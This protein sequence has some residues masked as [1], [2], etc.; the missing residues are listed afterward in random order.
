[1]ACA[2]AI[3]SIVMTAVG[4]YVANGGLNEVFGG[5]PVSGTGQ[6]L[7]G[8][9]QVQV[10]MPDGTS[11]IM[12]NVQ[13]VQKGFLDA[14]S[15]GFFDSLK[16]TLSDMYNSVIEFTAPMKE[17][18]QQMANAP[19]A[20]GNEVFLQT[21]GT[22][23]PKTAGL[24]QTLTE[25]SFKAALTM[26]QTWAVQSLGGAG[27][28]AGGIIQGDP[29]VLGGIY[30][31]AQSLVNGANS[32]VNAAEKSGEWLKT[33]FTTMDKTITAG[34]TGVSNW[35]EGLGDDIKNLGQTVSWENVNN[36]GS[37]GQLLANMENNGTLGPL[38]SKLSNITIS[39]K[40]A[41]ELGYNIAKAGVDIVTGKKASVGVAD[42]TN[43]VVTLGSLGVDLNSLART[44]AY[45]PAP[46]QKQVF[47]VLGTLTPTE[48]AQ[49]K[50][51]LNNKQQ[52]V[53]T[54]QDLLNPQKLFGK[55]YTTLT[56]PVRTA[57]VGFRAIYE[58]ESGSV[59]PQLNHLGGK[60][61]GIIPD[62]LAVANDALARSLLQIKG[63]QNTSTEV[64]AATISS[65]EV[66]EDLPLIQNQKQYITDPVA[67]YWKNTFNTDTSDIP[68]GTGPY[69]KLVVCDVIGLAAGYNSGPN[70]VEN[71]ELLAKLEAQ[72]AFDEFTTTQG[73]YE[74]IQE[75]CAGTFGPTED[76]MTPG[77]WYV[78]I[79]SGW[80]AAGT[81]GPFATEE[82]AFED[83]WLTGII[84]ATVL[85]NVDI[86]ANNTEAQ[87]VYTN[88]IRW[89]EQQGREYLN[90]QRA[91][92][93]VTAIPPTV[94]NAMA[95]ADSVKSAAEDTQ[96]GGGAMFFERVIDASTLGGQATVAMMRE[97]RNF[98]TLAA[99]GLQ[100][101]AA[102]PTDGIEEPG[103]LAPS[104]YTEQQANDLVIRS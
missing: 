60:L 77:D 48:T 13:A 80:A 22:Y 31:T 47:E 55:S 7:P 2:G 57:S 34:V 58:N 102:I 54:G 39:E 99:A 79:P 101:D 78:E 74:T 37:P 32:F 43:N 69:G 81:Y 66:L 4:S 33:T 15:L 3:T 12:S 42:L 93:D 6:A 19:V 103:Y 63:I 46:I 67:D 90:R 82:E 97:T 5:A 92:L 8:A 73:I 64:L 68:L 38:Y 20:A 76:P 51:I 24:F 72:G 100:Q 26:G 87:T 61:K 88:D 14:S 27:T 29:K 25:N 35:V 30:N 70:L 21:V 59:N 18:W 96:F 41:Q 98:K 17:A 52:A 10:F 95:L 50:A 104:Q 36:T 56:T 49:V 84:P 75:F 23:G 89:Q 83:A 45:M 53:V 44:G 86:V 28:L 11:Q 85:A 1:M 40:T 9:G 65:Q 71:A 94:Q 16:L 91:D 62:D